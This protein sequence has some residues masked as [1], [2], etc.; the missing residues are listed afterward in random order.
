MCGA[1]VT[2]DTAQHMRKA[3]PTERRLQWWVVK[4][5]FE[6]ARLQRIGKGKEANLSESVCLRPRGRIARIPNLSVG[7]RER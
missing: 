2:V 1:Q 6:R 3:H 4:S 5:S 7:R